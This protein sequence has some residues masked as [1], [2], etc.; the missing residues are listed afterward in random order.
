MF[1]AADVANLLMTSTRDWSQ[2]VDGLRSL[3]SVAWR[4]LSAHVRSFALANYSTR[5][6]VEKWRVVFEVVA[7]EGTISTSNG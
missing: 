1:H 6:L 4:N 2:A 5:A 7:D 3:S